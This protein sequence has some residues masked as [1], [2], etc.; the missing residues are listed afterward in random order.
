MTRTIRRRRG[1]PFTTLAVDLLGGAIFLR[2]VTLIPL[3]VLTGFI[4]FLAF[5]AFTSA[6]WVIYPGL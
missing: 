3:V 2:R 1:G 5:I 4:A 6:P